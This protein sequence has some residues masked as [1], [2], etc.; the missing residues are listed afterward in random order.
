MKRKFIYTILLGASLVLGSCGKDFLNITQIDK[1]TGN[2][3]WTSENDVEQYMG[4]IYSTFRE[5][6][7]SNIF[8]L[9][10]ET[11]VVH[12]SIEQVPQIIQVEIIWF[13]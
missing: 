12:R 8:S 2:N 9:Q 1:L 6:T 13:I 5:A 3:Y 10:V 4:G 11:Y 7:M